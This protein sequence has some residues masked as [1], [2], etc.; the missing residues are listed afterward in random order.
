MFQ[1][2]AKT[3]TASQKALRAVLPLEV[4]TQLHKF[5]ETEDC[6][7]E[8][9]TFYTIQIC[10]YKV[11][12]YVIPLQDREGM[13]PLRSCLLDAGRMFLSRAELVISANSEDSVDA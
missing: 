2:Q 12:G 13:L 7:L 9:L 3:G 10:K 1:T 11:M 4:K 6:T 5:F 8:S